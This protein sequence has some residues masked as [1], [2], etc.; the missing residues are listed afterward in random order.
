MNP[1]R[2]ALSHSIYLPK[3]LCSSL[4]QETEKIAHLNISLFLRATLTATLKLNTPLNTPPSYRSQPKKINKKNLLKCIQNH[5]LFSN[6]EMSLT[7]KI[8]ANSFY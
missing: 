7:N 3:G 4:A 5:L 8:C 1:F 6:I 2:R